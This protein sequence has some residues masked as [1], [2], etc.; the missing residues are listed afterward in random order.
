MRQKIRSSRRIPEYDDLGFISSVAMNQS[1]LSH[2]EMR[3]VL[4]RCLA[5]LEIQV[6]LRMDRL[7]HGCLG[8]RS[9]R[10][11]AI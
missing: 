8:M 11:C 2:L 5:G 3:P 7:E 1:A 10:S 9:E 4:G 6:D